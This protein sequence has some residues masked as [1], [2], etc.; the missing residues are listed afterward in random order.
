MLLNVKDFGKIINYVYRI[1]KESDNRTWFI[2][3]ED[4]KMGGLF[5]RDDLSVFWN[6]DYPRFKQ[7]YRDI[8]DVG[9]LFEGENDINNV[10]DYVLAI[11]G[12]FPCMF[13][14]PD[15]DF[16]FLKEMNFTERVNLKDIEYYLY[17][18]YENEFVLYD[19]QKCGPESFLIGIESLMTNRNDIPQPFRFSILI[20]DIAMMD[21]FKLEE[22]IDL[23]LN[24]QLEICEFERGY[25]KDS[26]LNI[27]NIV[28]TRMKD[29][30]SDFKLKHI[31]NLD[32]FINF[33]EKES[34]ER[35]DFKNLSYL[36]DEYTER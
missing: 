1:S 16:Q 23:W 32:E 17:D 24:D 27:Y 19:I 6:S 2:E 25:S 4:F 33:I 28:K 14:N 15:N 21:D 18:Y 26:I 31:V 12:D 7:Y 22:N 9:T 11:Y 8:V 5:S 13:Y 30:F 10:S 34:E 3:P 29:L 20:K 36:D 35:N